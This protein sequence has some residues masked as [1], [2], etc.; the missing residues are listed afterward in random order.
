MLTSKR[1]ERSK[2]PWEGALRI[3]NIHAITRS[4]LGLE[5]IEIREERTFEKFV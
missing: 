3:T 2:A 4:E 5:N 1:V